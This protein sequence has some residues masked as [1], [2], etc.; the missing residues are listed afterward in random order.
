[1]AIHLSGRPE[2][3]LQ[4]EIRT[5]A[6]RLSAAFEARLAAKPSWRSDKMTAEA[7][8]RMLCHRPL[9]AVDRGGRMHREPGVEQTRR[10]ADRAD[11]RPAT[12]D[13]RPAFVNAARF[14]RDFRSSGDVIACVFLS[15]LW[16]PLDWRRWPGW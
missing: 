9:Q 14:A 8:D 7:R 3:C 13:P 15:G 1:M 2:R 11:L 12:R 10:G 16:R 4:V 6:D 5:M